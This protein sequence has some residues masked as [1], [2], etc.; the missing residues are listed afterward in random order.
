MLRITIFT[1]IF[2][3]LSC[4]YRYRHEPLENIELREKKEIK[5]LDLKFEKNPDN[6]FRFNA[7]FLAFIPLV[8][9]APNDNY[10]PYDDVNEERIPIEI[11]LKKYLKVNL[12]KRFIINDINYSDSGKETIS[13]LLIIGKTKLY[14][15]NE[16]LHTFAVS[17]A[18]LALGFFG[19]PLIHQKCYVDVDFR[20]RENKSNAEIFQ[21]E[22]HGYFSIHRGFYYNNSNEE[23]LRIHNRMIIKLVRK[24]ILDSENYLIKQ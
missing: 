22:Y 1:I 6:S 10:S 4:F 23:V 16:T 2:F 17:F 21:K 5:T 20:I 8:L 24:F 14:F 18:A 9:S 13:D 15:C 3:Q 19:V 12:K 7:M 11:L